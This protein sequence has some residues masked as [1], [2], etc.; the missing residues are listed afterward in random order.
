MQDFVKPVSFT[1]DRLPWG[2]WT[3][4]HPVGRVVSGAVGLGSLALGAALGGAATWTFWA[5]L[6][7]PDTAL[8]YDMDHAGPERG[9]LSPRA[10]RLYNLLHHPMLP[11]TMIAVGAAT[12]GQP[13]I[14]AG[15]AWGAHIGIDRALGYGFRLEDG[16]RC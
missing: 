5:A 3:W 11:V 10:A 2:A 7:A 16:R 4:R 9:Q 12:F 6:I 15:L 13:L 1:G 8:L 14:V